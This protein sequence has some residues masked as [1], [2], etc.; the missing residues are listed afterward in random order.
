MSDTEELQEQLESL[1]SEHRSLDEKI[2]LLSEEGDDQ[3]LLQRLKRQKLALKDKILA[4]EADILPDI[5]A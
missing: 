5:I 1:K 3:L 2:T 4:L